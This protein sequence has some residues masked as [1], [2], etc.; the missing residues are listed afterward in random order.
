MPRARAFSSTP[1]ASSAEYIRKRLPQPMARIDTDAPVR[2]SVRWGMVVAAAAV[3][4][5]RTPGNAAAAPAMA[6]FSRNS[7]RE[8][9]SRFMFGSCLLISGGELTSHR[10]RHEL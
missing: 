3:E 7:R 5:A 6:L 9:L 1:A 8:T 4:V 2:P 10:G